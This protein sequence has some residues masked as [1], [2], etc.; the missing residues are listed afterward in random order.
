MLI[1]IHTKIGSIL[2]ERPEALEAVMGI[3]PKFEKLKNPLL[4]KVIAGRTSIAMASKVAGC[5]VAEFFNR[6]RPLGFETDD[7]L[8]PGATAEEKL[9]AFIY[10]L[11]K[12]QVVEL[13][14]R[15]MIAAGTDPL[16][17]IVQQVRSIKPGQVLKIVS[18]FYPAPLIQLLEKQGFGA[19][20][21]IIDDDLV[22]TWFIPKADHV[23]PRVMEPASATGGEWDEKMLQYK[24]HLLT[25]DVRDLEM[26]Q[27][28]ISILQALDELPPGAALLVKHRKIPVFLLPELAER[29]FS[30][31][32]RENGEG[33]VDLLIYAK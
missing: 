1:N 24:D 18:N 11:K 5:D 16:E 30:Y 27:P 6:L 2:K 21:D 7:S 4:R 20:A 19:F 14:V 23:S 8:L 32:I 9:P 15:A 28:M 13:D 26:P 17:S 3:S 33:R 10:R 12:E 29:S 25:L 31:Q 22:E